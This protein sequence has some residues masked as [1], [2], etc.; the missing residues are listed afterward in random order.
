MTGRADRESRRS[1]TCGQPGGC[2]QLPGQGAAAAVFAVPDVVDVD[3]PESDEEEE[4]DL[5]AESP[6]LPAG[7]EEVGEEVV[8]LVAEVEDLLE[9]ERE[10]VR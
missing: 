10:S 1:L 7:L 2:G 3:L 4:D 6:D 5:A 9:S 8:S